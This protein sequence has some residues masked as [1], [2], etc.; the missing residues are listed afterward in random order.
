MI[1]F[2][3]PRDPY[4]YF[5]NFSRHPVDIYGRIWP[6]SEHAFQGMKFHP[7][8]PDLV[9]L[10]HAAPTPGRAANLGRGGAGGGLRVDWDQ[11]PNDC[12]RDGMNADRIPQ[13]PQPVDN[14]GRPGVHAE[15]L[16]QRAKDVFMF[17]IC[18][19]KFRQ[20]AELRQGILSTGSEALIED[21]L[22]DP[23][24]G[25]SASHIGENKL[26]RILMAVRHV[27][28]QV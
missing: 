18:L 19:A 22:H 7:H 8:R 13:V 10:V 14:I 16:F 9:S 26:G 17:E 28:Q 27:L 12:Y 1:L 21:A 15:P 4:G 20:N 2:Y 3:D 11:A 25:W 5:S 24:W 6:T 23:Y